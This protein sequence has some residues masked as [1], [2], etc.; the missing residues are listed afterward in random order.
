MAKFI[1]LR[2]DFGFKY[3]MSDPIIMKSFLNAILDGDEE[4]ITDVTFENVE[5]P[6][7]TEDQRGVIFDLLC[8]TDKGDT[9][10][11]E[12]QNSNQKFFK[13]RANFYIYNLLRKKIDRGHVWKKMKQDISKIIGIFIMGDGLNG[14]DK[15]IT[16]TAECDLD[17]G[18]EF[19]NRHRKYFISLP[20]FTLDINNITNKDIWI[21]FLKNL[22]S[23]DKIHPSVYER[24]DEGL[25]RLLKKANIAALT[26]EDL[27]YYEASMKRLEDE[28]DME[29]IG[30]EKGIRDKAVQ[31]AIDMKRDGVDPKNIAKWTDLTLDEIEKL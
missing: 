26:D 1:D 22:G 7:E 24:A 30:Y 20:Q 11:I 2:C 16:R 31:I 3:C 27:D 12:M 28:M 15:V 14:L 17:T 19:W 29:E 9:I 8:T 21:D 23:M 25:L 10:L 5:I 6:R 13:T 4:T 18:C